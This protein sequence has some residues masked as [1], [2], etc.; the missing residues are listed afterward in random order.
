MALDEPKDD[1][2]VFDVDG[3]Q[4]IVNNYLME[5]AKPIKVDFLNVGFKI[6]CGIDFGS[7]SGCAGCSCG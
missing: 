5:K 1:D 3:F 6:D 2:S 4:Y 7:A